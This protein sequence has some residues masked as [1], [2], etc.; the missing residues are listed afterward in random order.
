MRNIFGGGYQACQDALRRGDNDWPF[1]VKSLLLDRELV[2]N[3]FFLKWFGAG[4]ISALLP[5]VKLKH[6]SQSF[7]RCNDAVLGALIGYCTTQAGLMLIE[8]T[9]NANGRKPMLNPTTT[10]IFMAIVFALSL[11]RVNAANITTQFRG[12]ASYYADKFHGRK[13]ASGEVYNQTRLTCAHP[14]LPFGT[15]LLVLN[16]DNG[17]TC[18]VRV[19]DRGPFRSSRIIDL[20]KAAARKLHISGVRHVVCFKLGS[21]KHR[22]AIDPDEMVPPYRYRPAVDGELTAHHAPPR[23]AINVESITAD[24]Q[25]PP[26]SHRS[27]DKVSAKTSSNSAD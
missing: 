13:T 27:S 14:F 1:F 6:A 4:T 26:S 21:H 10:A 16:P 8:P 22:P 5:P 23:Q 17:L 2:A 9:Q 18:V 24:A 19:N 20:S 3:S 7:N 15:R 25:L 12:A 11:S